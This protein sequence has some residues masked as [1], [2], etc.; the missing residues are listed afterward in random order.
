M[1]SIQTGK[2]GKFI[3][4]KLV[5]ET[6]GEYVSVIPEFGGNVDE[7]VLG[8]KG[9][10]YP[11]LEVFDNDDMVKGNPKYKS[12]QL[13]P[14]A[15]R[16]ADGKYSF[17]GKSYQLPINLGKNA[18]HGLLLA[19]PMKVTEKKANKNHAS[20]KLEYKYKG[21]VPGYPFKYKAVITYS[22]LEK[23]GFVCETVITNE[24]S[25]PIP[26]GHGWHPYYRTK[27]KVDRL[28]LK[29][30][31]IYRVEVVE[32]IPT[33]KLI[34]ETY[35]EAVTIGSQECD[36]GF[37]VPDKEGAVSAELYDPELDI[38]LNIWQETGKGKYNYMQTYIPENRNSIAIEPMSSMTDAV[39]NK[40]GL[41]VLE[42][43]QSFKAKFGVS[44]E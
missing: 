9:V 28:K 38:K 8:K 37:V 3:K 1:F 22:L 26:V 43:G 34:P 12:T 16:I 10:T 13:I 2:L 35:S 39:N 15:N 6:T 33:G 30:P 14:F 11:V 19:N 21:E 41:I 18:C 4:Y 32:L 25:S 40:N 27:G 5:N 36:A 23:V 29:L 20:I 42:P 7:I 31:S 44:L 17:N 24:D